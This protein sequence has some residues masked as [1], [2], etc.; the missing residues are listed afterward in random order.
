MKTLPAREL[1]LSD[2][3]IDRN[4][5]D[6]ELAT[7]EDEVTERVAEAFG[8]IAEARANYR[9]TLKAYLD[10]AGRGDMAE[11]A[12]RLDRTRESL[13]R[14]AHMATE[15]EAETLAATATLGRPKFVSPDDETTAEIERVAE[16]CRVWRA[17]EAPLW[18]AIASI[19]H[20][21]PDTALCEMTGVSRATLNRKLGPRPKIESEAAYLA[22]LGLPS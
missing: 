20:R 14:D 9:R 18:D 17:G 1:Y 16:M 10:G 15:F 22:A 19:R 3:W 8:A 7:S 5:R 21:V 2:T 6:A 11:L 13:R 4:P 12:R